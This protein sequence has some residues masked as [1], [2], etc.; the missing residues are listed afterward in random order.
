MLTQTSQRMF[1]L[2]FRLWKSIVIA[3]PPSCRHR[4]K[5][6]TL[7]SYPLSSRYIV[8]VVPCLC[9]KAKETKRIK[10]DFCSLFIF[11]TLETLFLCF[12]DTCFV[13]Q[14][15]YFFY[16]RNMCCAEKQGSLQLSLWL[17]YAQKVKQNVRKRLQLALKFEKV[18]VFLR[19]HAIEITFIS[20]APTNLL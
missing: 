10:E 7:I 11:I 17:F 15:K 12:N 18:S 8:V 9:L 1:A 13:L 2:A 19:I 3:V 20:W 4:E 16:S 14:W 6:H 5:S